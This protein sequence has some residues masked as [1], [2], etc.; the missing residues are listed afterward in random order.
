MEQN[1]QNHS[2]YVPGYHLI[3]SLLILLGTIGA[4]VNL[5]NSIKNNNL[6]SASL[7]LILFVAAILIFWY[8]RQ[9]ALKAQ[10]RAIKAEENLRYFSLTG[11]LMPKQLRMSQIIALRF[12]SD[13]EL[14]KLV[15]EVVSKNLNAK[16]IKIS[17]KNWKSD[18]Y[19]V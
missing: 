10:D 12:A 16:D 15:D 1:Y 13:E 4:F 9:F 7:I 14:L 5:L 17:I 19:R 8:L 11:K 18:H 2:K 3:L 6:Y